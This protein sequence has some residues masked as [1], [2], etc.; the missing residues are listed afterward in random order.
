[1]LKKYA[2]VWDASSKVRDEMEELSR[3]RIEVAGEKVEVDGMPCLIVR[4]ENSGVFI[5][6]EGEYEPRQVRAAGMLCQTRAL[7]LMTE[8]DEEALYFSF[9][10]EDLFAFIENEVSRSVHTR[11]A[12]GIAKKA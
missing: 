8:G 7:F 1:M 6:V 12:G 10:P 11:K 9:Y 3:E 2:K 5:D 4:L